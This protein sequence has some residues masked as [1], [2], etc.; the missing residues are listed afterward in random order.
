MP[1]FLRSII[2]VHFTL[3]FIINFFF[4]I[5]FCLHLFI[6]VYLH[7]LFPS[8]LHL[9]VSTFFVSFI[10]SSPCI[11][12][13]CFLHL[14]VSTFFVSLRA[15]FLYPDVEAASSSKRRFIYIR[16]KGVTCL[17]IK[18]FNVNAHRTS[19]VA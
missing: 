8:S 16:L 4:S 6:S 3:L 19:I 10:S 12:I 5:H 2:L 17:T 7:S 11:Y 9:R 13:L 1:T 15:S 14:R 18:I